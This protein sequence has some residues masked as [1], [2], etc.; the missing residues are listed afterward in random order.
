LIGSR[1][2]TVLGCLCGAILVL[3]A[4]STPIRVE[5][6]TETEMDTAGFNVYRGESPDGPFDVKVNAELIPPSPDP[7]SGGTYSVLD[8]SARPGVTYYY[9][10]QEVEKTGQVSLH[11][12]IQAKGSPFSWQ[13]SLILAV[14]ALVVLGLWVLGGR[15]AARTAQAGEREMEDARD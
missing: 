3:A 1:W 14:L 5:W 9:Q 2:V 15:R 7:L 13:Q 8:R 6:S 10:L 11:G 4:C 12:P